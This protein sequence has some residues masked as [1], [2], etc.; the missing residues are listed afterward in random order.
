MKWITA[1]DIANWAN[2][3]Q[4]HCQ[5]TMPELVGRLILAHTANAVEEFDF[6]SGN[7][8]AMGGWDG[9]LKTPVNSLFF[10]TG[11]SGWEIGTEKS[12]QTKAEADYVKRIAD[13]LG[14]TAHGTTFV[15]V[16][17]RSFPKRNAWKTAKK[18]MGTWKDAKVIAADAL[19]QWVAITPAV[20]L[21]LARQIGKVVSNGIR[22]L[23]AVWE[24]WSIGTKPI[25]TPQLVIGGRTRDAESVQKWI[26]ERP[27][28]LEVQGDHPDESYAFLYAAIATLPDTEKAQ[29]F[30]R[31]VV[32]ENKTEMRQLV[33]AFPN[34]PLIIAGPG[35]CLD[36]AHAAVAKGHHV[37][38]SMDATVVGIHNVLRLARPQRSVVEKLLH[39]GGLSEADALRIARDSGR[40]IPVLRR[41]LFQ[42]NAVSAPAWA[43]DESAKILL[44]VLFANAWDEHKDGDRQI[45][46]TLT[47]RG[48]DAFVKELTPF[49]SIDDAPVRKVGSVW[50][51][52]SPLDTWYLLAPHLTQG[53]LKLFETALLSVLTKTDP[54]YEL[55]P[56]K[57]WAAAI[58]GK[59]NP[60]SEWLRTGFVESLMLIAVHGSQSPSLASAQEFAD[61]IV[62]TVFTNA[63]SWEAWS[64]LKEASPLLS[65]A[66][67]DTFME[68][69]EG[70]I[71]KQPSIFQDLMKDDVRGIVGECRHSGLLWSLEGIAWSTEYF[72]RAVNALAELANIDPCGGWNNRAVNSLGEIFMPGFPQTHAQPKER[73]EVLRQLIAKYPKLVWKFAEDYYGGGTIS[74]SHR[75]R[76]RET[77]GQRRGLEQETN[78]E[79]KE[80]L[81]GLLPMLQNLACAREN[82]VASMDEFIRLPVDTRERL[83]TTIEALDPTTF[84]K[85]EKDLLLQKT[86]EALNWINSYD[87][88]DRSVHVS[89]LNLILEKFAPADVIERV[90]WLLSNPWPR[91][92][93]GE[94]KQYDAK[95]MSVKEAQKAAAREVLDTAPVEKI[96]GFSS[97]IQYQGVLGHALAM[98]VRDDQEDETVLTALLA[99][100]K[101]MPLLTRGYAMGRVEAVGTQWVDMTIERLKAEEGYLPEGCALLY[102][103]LPE[104]AETW[105]AV[106]A[107]GKEEE[108]AYWKQASGYSRADKNTDAPIA[109]EKLLDAERPF[110]ALQVAGSPDVDIPSKLL[111][112]LL[113]EILNAQDKKTLGDVM[114]EFHLGH[115]FRQLYEKN[116]LSID[117]MVKLEWPFAALFDELKRYTSTPMALHRALQTDPACFAQ[118]VSFIYKRDNR[119][120]NP[121]EEDVNEEIRERRARVAHEVLDSWYLL[122]GLKDDGSVDEKA[123]SDWITAARKRCEETNHVIGC[124]LQIGFILA[125]APADPDG[126]W[127]HT[128]VRNIVEQLNNQTIDDHI[129]NEIYNSRGVTS[130]GLNDGGNQER[131]LVEK[132][133]KLS[134]AVKVR[135]PRTATLLRS[136]AKFYEHEAKGHDVESDLQ[137]LRWG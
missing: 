6:P 29:A 53:Q 74:E 30:A 75:F 80:Y 33:Q 35:E 69:L 84:S 52:K 136:I 100:T 28:I 82:V 87:E 77:G 127:P 63:S 107:R 99:R 45:I 43:K 132:Y 94:P 25:M 98:A 67:P 65:E 68:A 79:Y 19:E 125:H 50:M 137:D 54:K 114:D 7:S 5:D 4:R 78:A 81:R 110:A 57:R 55:E 44:P 31:C 120:E 60:Y 51:T 1:S 73:L 91:L 88:E 85:E 27:A 131:A 26:A 66:S 59:A 8:V 12:A 122:P 46:E 128:T 49:L 23:E 15:F 39:E 56:E 95:D 42:S 123:L 16:T 20:G 133:K 89:G 105:A 121:S 10:P 112:R 18:A 40:S 117:E 111:Q 130:R 37:F 22:N 92:P 113:Q 102:F 9:R 103:G 62:R 135:W 3:Q 48:Y 17:P 61:H 104:C 101:D 21:W 90:G 129:Q 2:T 108:A 106:A 14:M 86:R 134:E 41:H 83:L 119:A 93:Q 32:V 64:S 13:P 11:A 124:D 72:A 47:G 96:L 71:A 24:E 126:T 34:Y 76:W 109:V 58:Y 118:L 115:V 70:W 36:G 116:E 38:I 97:T